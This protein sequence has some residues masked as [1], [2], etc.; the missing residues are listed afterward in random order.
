MP[1]FTYGN[2]T[3]D[4]DLITAETADDVKITVE[5]MEGITVIA[6]AHVTPEHLSP[7]LRK[8]APWIIKKWSE[9]NE[10]ASLPAPKEFVSGEK[11]P[12]IGRQ[13]RLKVLTSHDAEQPN[14]TFHQN[15]FIATVPQHW[16]MQTR[17]EWLRNAFRE[18]YTAFGSIKLKE[19]MARFAKLLG[20]QPIGLTLKEQKM[21][22]GSC[23]KTG[24]ILI[25]WRLV[26]APARVIDYVLVHELTHMKVPDHS[27]DFWRL[28]RGV[29]PDYEERKEW[30]RVNGPTL[31]L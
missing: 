15:T 18:W 5:W 17:R 24:D 9:L 23:T 21:R 25:N 31:T 11:F 10:I 30:L 12:Y 6:P 20:V 7:I 2:S 3:F 22:W 8:K 19:R 13:Y 4:Y 16:D 14:F 1:F 28:V 29:L 26:M 27:A